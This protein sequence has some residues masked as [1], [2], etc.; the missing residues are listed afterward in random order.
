MDEKLLY[1][2]LSVDFCVWVR[3]THAT[4]FFLCI[5]VLLHTITEEILDRSHG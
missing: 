5:Y 2:S 4:N 1:D 3:N